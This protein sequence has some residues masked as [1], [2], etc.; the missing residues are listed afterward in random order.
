MHPDTFPC[1][2]LILVA[3]RRVTRRG[4][5]ACGCSIS[6][7]VL[8]CYFIYLLIFGHALGMWKSLGQ[9]LNPYHPSS[10]C[11]CSDNPDRSLIHRATRDPYHPRSD[12]VPHTTTSSR[13]HFPTGSCRAPT[14]GLAL[15][16][17]HLCIC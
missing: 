10:L 7:K 2:N 16:A 3:K 8:P 12:G 13:H 9:G 6:G 15:P 5:G 14:S 17:K 4:H 1:P 11:C